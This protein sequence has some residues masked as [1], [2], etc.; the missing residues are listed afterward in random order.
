MSDQSTDNDIPPWLQE[1]PED[2]DDG[3]SRLTGRRALILT[4]VLAAFVVIGF[5]SL[6]WYFGTAAQPDAEVIHVAAPAEPYK[7]KPDAPGGMTVPHQDKVV[8]EA[9]AGQARLDGPSDMAE[10]AEQPLND[11]SSAVAQPEPVE[12]LLDKADNTPVVEEETPATAAEPEPARVEPVAKPVETPLEVQPEP[13]AV[14]PDT[15]TAAFQ[16]QLGAFSSESAARA[17]WRRARG[18]VPTVLADAPVLYQPVSVGTR[19][20]IR[21]RAGAYSERAEADAACLAIRAK[22]LACI[23]VPAQPAVLN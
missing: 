6:I 12:T 21:L 3:A 19:T 15:P 18:A 4:G 5:V 13:A 11:P 2:V 10:A 23:A 16:I 9:A 14:D 17:A 7:E 8:L 1:V 20:L 22:E